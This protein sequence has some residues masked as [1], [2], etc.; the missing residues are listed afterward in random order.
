MSIFGKPMSQISPLD[1]HELLEQKAVENVRL[2]FKRDIPGKD[3][4]LKK[5]SSFANTFGGFLVIGAEAKS[6]D[7][8]IVGSLES[9]SRMGTSRP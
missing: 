7:G 5:L 2:E 4:T 6:S 9:T 1:L 8:R 3:E